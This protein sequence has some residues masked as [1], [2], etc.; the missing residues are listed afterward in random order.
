MRAITTYSCKHW[1]RCP[2]LRRCFQTPFSGRVVSGDSYMVTPP[3]GHPAQLALPGFPGPLAP[4]SAPEGYS[5]PAPSMSPQMWQFHAF[6]LLRQKEESNH[7]LPDK[8]TESAPRPPARGQFR[9]AAH[10]QSES[11]SDKLAGG[12]RIFFSVEQQRFN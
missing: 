10:G 6:L 11:Q 8:W 4:F 2:S 9:F 7:R 1:R 3:P 12:E 5:M